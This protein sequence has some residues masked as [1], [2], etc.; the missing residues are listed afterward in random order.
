MPRAQREGKDDVYPSCF[1][2]GEPR[3]LV[4]SSPRPSSCRCRRHSSRGERRT[5]LDTPEE[6]DG[7]VRGAPKGPTGRRRGRPREK[8][9]YGR[10]TA[11]TRNDLRWTQTDVGLRSGRCK[12]V[13]GHTCGRERLRRPR[14][15]ERTMSNT[16]HPTL[17][18]MDPTAAPWR[19]HCV[20]VR[21]PG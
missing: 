1:P 21:R 7:T 16:N 10:T 17:L 6:D 20:G 12:A 5:D 13:Q 9:R 19:G 11:G 8:H 14:Q 2:D 3:L 15:G 4:S 18:D